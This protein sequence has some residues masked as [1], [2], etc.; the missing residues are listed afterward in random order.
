MLAGA[1]ESVDFLSRY[2]LHDKTHDFR[3]STF[4]LADSRLTLR[5]LMGLPQNVK[6]PIELPAIGWEG[7]YLGGNLRNDIIIVDRCEVLLVRLDALD[8][9]NEPH[10]LYSQ[11]DS[12]ASFFLDCFERLWNQENLDKAKYNYLFEEIANQKPSL[13]LLMSKSL[14]D[15]L[16]NRFA[17]NFEQIHELNPREFEEF[18]AELLLREG[19]DVQ[20]TGKTRDGGHDIIATAETPIGKALYLV[21]CKKFSEHRKVGVELIRSLHSVVETKGATQGLLVTTS[22][23]SRDAWHLC[24]EHK[25]RISAKDS[26]SLDAWIREHSDS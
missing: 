9:P 19:M 1:S 26:K 24:S 7:K 2:S 12:N 21:E 14:W 13:V 25:D 22:S 11:F 10:Y 8:D 23:L 17:K 15:P 20:L 18:V 4:A 5:C 16:I 6:V 3:E